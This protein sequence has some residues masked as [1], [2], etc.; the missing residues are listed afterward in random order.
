M[1]N[2]MRVSRL[3]RRILPNHRSDRENVVFLVSG[4]VVVVAIME[5]VVETAMVAAV[6]LP[7][8]ELLWLSLSSSS[9][10]SSAHDCRSC[11]YSLATG[12]WMRY[13]SKQSR[14]ELIRHCP[15]QR[16]L[17]SCSKVGRSLTPK[18]PYN[19]VKKKL[20]SSEHWRGRQHRND[21]SFDGSNRTKFCTCG[22]VETSWAWS[23]KQGWSLVALEQFS[24]I[25]FGIEH[26]SKQ[27]PRLKP[28]KPEN[29]RQHANHK[30]LGH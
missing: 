29:G 13:K 30:T 6:A 24:Q 26:P 11:Q 20:S 21:P 17:R 19:H 15:C 22:T 12:Q 28:L 5:I 16:S 27:N 25:G 9:W 2:L 14:P 1:G 18:Q 3:E 10:L 4:V 23:G 7:A 8:A